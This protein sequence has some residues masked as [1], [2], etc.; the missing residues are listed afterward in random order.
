MP[1]KL[2]GKVS[3]HCAG[4]D[5]EASLFMGA[6]LAMQAGKSQINPEIVQYDE[7]FLF[8]FK[9]FKDSNVVRWICFVYCR[10]Q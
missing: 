9:D 6:L 3:Y 8:S 4:D 5:S 7:P 1:E 10:A 2:G